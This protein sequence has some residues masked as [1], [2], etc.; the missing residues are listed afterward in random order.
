MQSCGREDICKH[1][2][3]GSRSQHLLCHEAFQ[4]GEKRNFSLPLAFCSIDAHIF[5]RLVYKADVL[6]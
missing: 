1:A 6:G 2:L 4:K 3:E 5:Q